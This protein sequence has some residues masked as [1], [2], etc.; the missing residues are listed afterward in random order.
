M[1]PEGM[2]EASFM[3]ED[4]C[5]GEP[6]IVANT[7]GPNLLGRDVLRLLR[8]NWEKLLNVYYLE[9]N[10]RTENCLDKILSN[11]K[12]VFKSEMGTLKGF[13]VE[14][15]VD[16][17]CKPT[18]CKARPVPYALNERIEKELER[19]VKDHIHESIQ[20]S[21]RAAP[22]VPILKDD[23][24]VRICGDYKQTINQASLC[25]K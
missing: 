8:L 1:K 23:G 20:Y 9:E 15:K 16:P 17:D 21:K 4:Q 5:L 6:F 2:I 18:F 3:Y 12:E 22:I 13:E 7:K 11:Y 24:T 10:V 25:D 19:L 14:L